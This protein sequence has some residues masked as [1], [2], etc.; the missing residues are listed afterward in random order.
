[1]VIVEEDDS[2]EHFTVV[3]TEPPTFNKVNEEYVNATLILGEL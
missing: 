1:M 2:F 3:F